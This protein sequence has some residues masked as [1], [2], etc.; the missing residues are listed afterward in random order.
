MRRNP[1]SRDRKHC[2]R[3]LVTIDVAGLVHL[4]VGRAMA[5]SIQQHTIQKKKALQ[6]SHVL[7]ADKHPIFLG[8]QNNTFALSLEALNRPESTRVLAT[9]MSAKHCAKAS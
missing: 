2:R 7:S 8:A 1:R 5:S 9:A 3:E 6:N 4:G